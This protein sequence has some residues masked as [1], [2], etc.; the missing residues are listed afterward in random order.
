[1]N[2][3][4]AEIHFDKRYGIWGH[5]YVRRKDYK[6]KQEQKW[7]TADTQEYQFSYRRGYYFDKIRGIKQKIPAK[8]KIF[9]KFNRKKC[10]TLEQ[11]G[12]KLK[13]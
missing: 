3:R 8:N 6:T 13:Q 4:L 5:C 7:I 10:L 9:P 2:G 12:N 1:M 11:L